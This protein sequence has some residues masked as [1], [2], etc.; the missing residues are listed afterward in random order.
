[1]N[2]Q[3]ITEGMR[4][5]DNNG[6]RGNVVAVADGGKLISVR[7][8]GEEYVRAYMPGQIEPYTPPTLAERLARRAAQDVLVKL[9]T[10]RGDNLWED[11]VY[12]LDYD[13][14]ATNAVAGP[15]DRD[16][17]IGGVHYHHNGAV[18]VIA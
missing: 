8:D 7:V 9:N 15:D 12:A 11:V 3:D 4:V 16:V 5:I 18:W 10:Y 1:M 6:T 17:V 13:E 2:A 14:A